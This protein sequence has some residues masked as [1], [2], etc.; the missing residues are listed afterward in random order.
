MGRVGGLCGVGRLELVL[1]HLA[2]DFELKIRYFPP[3]M[4]I[5]AHGLLLAEL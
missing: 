1:L 2:I 5:E 4:K 3:L